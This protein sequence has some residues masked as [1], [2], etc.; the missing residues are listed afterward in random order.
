MLKFASSASSTAEVHVFQISNTAMQLAYP[1][2][3]SNLAN[4]LSTINMYITTAKSTNVTRLSSLDVY[5]TSN[6]RRRSVTAVNIALTT[7]AGSELL[8]LAGNYFDGYIWMSISST[9]L[10]NTILSGAQP[11]FA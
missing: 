8:S 9:T 5:P 11:C 1:W 4:I 10:S 2:T 7:V 3:S 6:S